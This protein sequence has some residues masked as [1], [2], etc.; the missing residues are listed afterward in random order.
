VS[1]RVTAHRAVFGTMLARPEKSAIRPWLGHQSGT[2]PDMAQHEESIRPHS[3]GPLSAGLF[4]ARAG[5]TFWNSI[6][7]ELIIDTQDRWC[8]LTSSALPF[9]IPLS[10]SF[11]NTMFYSLSS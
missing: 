9:S 4:R 2:T 5:R 1:G 10:I 8:V 3:V 6:H 7:G 11:N